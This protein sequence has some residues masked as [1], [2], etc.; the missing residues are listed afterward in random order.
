MGC[1]Y[2]EELRTL[3]REKQI[4][5]LVQELPGIRAKFNLSCDDIERATNIGAKRVAAIEEGRQLP[6]WS[7]YLSIVFMLWINDSCRGI[8]DEKG[9]FPMELKRA[10]SVNRNAHEH[11]V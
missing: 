5:K 9:L 2:M 4:Q 3:D 11:T 1:V 7:E 8:L 10:F 6:K